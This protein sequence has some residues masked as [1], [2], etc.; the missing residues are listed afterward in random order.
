MIQRHRAIQTSKIF[1][2]KGGDNIPQTIEEVQNLTHE[3]ASVIINRLQRFSGS[4]RGT[5][6]WNIARRGE[7]LI[8]QLGMP[9]W[10]DTISSADT[11]WPQLQKLLRDTHPGDTTQH[12]R[13]INNPALCSEYFNTFISVVCKTILNITSDVR[14]IGE[15]TSGNT[16]VVFIYI[17][18]CGVMYRSHWNLQMTDKMN[19]GHMHVSL[20]TVSSPLVGKFS[21]KAPITSWIYNLVSGILILE[22]KSVDIIID[23]KKYFG[24]KISFS[25]TYSRMYSTD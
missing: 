15:G 13:V 20:G 17:A 19:N 7:D 18:F 10:F 5:P 1:L 21:P 2:K 4:I 23:P 8:D 6:G 22:C 14:I 3:H 16:V 24:D 9:H 25:R 11:H 12:Q